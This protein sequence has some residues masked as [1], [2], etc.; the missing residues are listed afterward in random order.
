M[1]KYFLK[2]YGAILRCIYGALIIASILLGA[3]AID[4]GTNYKFAILGFISWSIAA[5]LY[6][7]YL[8][9]RLDQNSITY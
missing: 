5:V 6:I 8:S 3:A 9:I 4:P 2:E 1:D 7:R